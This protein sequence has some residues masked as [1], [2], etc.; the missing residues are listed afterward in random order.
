MPKL[1]GQDRHCE[2]RGEDICGAG[3]LKKSHCESISPTW[4]EVVVNFGMPEK[5]ESEFL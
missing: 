1:L 4:L 3:A 2:V 5:A